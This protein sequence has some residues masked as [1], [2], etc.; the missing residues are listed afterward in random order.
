MNMGYIRKTTKDRPTGIC[1]SC[2][3][4]FVIPYGV[5]KKKFCNHSCY[6]KSVEK[7]HGADTK[8]PCLK[9]HASLLMTG[10]QSGRLLN[11]PKQRVSELRKKLGIKTLTNKE[12][13]PKALKRQYDYRYKINPDE[14][15]WGNKGVEKLWMR[16][17]KVKDFDWGS[18]WTQH[19]INTC[20][21]YY[22]M[23]DEE[24]LIH[25][26]RQWIRK[27]ERYATD[28]QYRENRKSY[29]GKWLMNNADKR[30]QYQRKAVKK[31][32]ILDPG[33]K[34]Q[35]NLRHR[36]KDIMG[37]VKKGGTEHR[38]NLTGC[39]TKQLASHLESQFKRGMTW[40]N[41]GKKWHVD[42]ILPCASFD[43]TDPNQVAQCW[44]WT[45][46]RALDA[47]TNMKK[48]DTITEPQMNL[49]LCSP[50]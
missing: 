30:R 48:S 44:H 32:K 6:A 18:I 24:R 21:S 5:T 40:E 4:S 31:R 16:Q 26:K 47:V 20:H 14:P 29:V 11:W 25:N 33:F 9:C 13:A 34:V 15:W 1:A 17:V 36:L 19:R 37:K 28:E 8:I 42:H 39:T 23:T 22:K 50:H 10:A 35:C 43:H 3:K 49:L 38:N 27:K 45:N 41:Y 46:L 7:R 2:G 12:A